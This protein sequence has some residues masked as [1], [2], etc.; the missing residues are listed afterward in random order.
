MRYAFKEINKKE[1]VAR[2]QYLY[3][4]FKLY[5]IPVK[6]QDGFIIL[7]S[8]PSNCISLFFI[9]GHRM[10]VINYLSKNKNCISEKNVVINSCFDKKFKKAFKK[11]HV[12][13]SHYDSENYSKIRDGRSYGIDFCVTNSELN[14]LNSKDNDPIKRLNKAFIKV[15]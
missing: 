14:L 8:I 3:D 2:N 1:L 11:K 12:F 5:F 6:T 9:T 15:E 13:V 4:V 10:D 7:Q